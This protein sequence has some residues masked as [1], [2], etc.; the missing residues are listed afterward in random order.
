MNQKDVFVSAGEADAYF[1]RNKGKYT[2]AV[3]PEWTRELELY[4]RY[5]T[6][7]SRVLEIGCANGLKLAALREATGC[8][9]AGIDPSPDAIADGRQRF[10]DLD[11]RVGTAD[12]IPFDDG[13]FDFVL[14]GFCLY[15]VDRALLP[16]T[17]AAADRVLVDGGFLG[18]TDFFPA[19]P[20][21]RE[22][23]HRPGVFSYKMDY[24]APFLAFR[25]YT[26]VE[27]V[28]YSHAGPEFARDPDDRIASLVL[29]K[30]LRGGYGLPVPPRATR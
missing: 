25:S 27:Q 12:D 28:G 29:H 14:F 8:A 23:A 6:R 3:S 20:V 22:Y 30:D 17:C 5:L 15:L 26:L 13:A 10:P 21:V 9:G 19:A 1:R 7:D 24:S 18:I 2:G 4:S 16:R 11:L